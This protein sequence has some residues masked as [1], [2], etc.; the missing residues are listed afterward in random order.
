[1]AAWAA[2]LMSALLAARV[3]VSECASCYEAFDDATG[4]CLDFIG[5]DVPQDDCCVNPKYGFKLDELSPCEAC[6]NAEWSPWSQWGPCSVTCSEGVQQRRR[7][8]YGQGKCAGDEKK[9]ENRL[10]TRACSLQDCCPKDGAWS[11][12]TPWSACSVTCETGT[13]VR[14]RTC[15]NPAP[16][17]G[18]TCPGAGQEILQCDTRQVCPTHGSWGS[19]GAWGQC[20]SSC[21]HEGSANLPHE[22]RS[23]Q[24]NN[25][26]PSTNPP[27]TFCPGPEQENRDCSGIPFCP[28]DGQ[29]GEWQR[30]SEC[31]ATCGVGRMT[32]KRFCNDPAPQHGGRHCVGSDV[33][34]SPC[35]TGVKCPID[36]RWTE[37]SDWSI[38][39]RSGMEIKCRKRDG[40][41]K[42]T[43]RCEDRK[44]GGKPCVGSTIETRS[45]YNIHFCVL[46]KSFWSEWSEWSLC[47]PP[48]GASARS[49]V[50]RCQPVFP[51]YPNTTGIQKINTVFFWGTPRAV[52]HELNGQRLKVEE[53][54][55]CQNVVECEEFEE[56]SG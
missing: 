39:A 11:N 42:R 10:E 48:C 9:L 7:A 29:W 35:I 13:M 23:R 30:D 36:G 52:C 14:G 37:W 21:V 40:M 22:A 31:S 43:R 32:E 27:G 55:P 33:R 6:H 16:I 44:F 12:W 3:K 51:D 47:K 28:V 19:W 54:Q 26:A 34:T 53:S 15:N 45:C 8:C 18:G 4:S 24:C 1:M 5:D 56:V 25:P 17:C 49:R 46:D 2:L 20:S 50:K 38:C 41:Q